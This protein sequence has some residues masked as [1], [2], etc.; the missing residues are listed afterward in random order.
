MFDRYTY[1]AW[2]PPRPP[3]VVAKRL[4]FWALAHACP[5]PDLVL[6]LDAPA[7]VVSARKPEE[8]LEEIAWQRRHFLDLGRRVPRLQ[9]VDATRP[10]AEVKADILER[11]WRAYL[12][13]SRAAG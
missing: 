6:L 11:L 4:Y 10:R 7:E 8:T 12:R 5:A 3:L 13:R 9:V 1:D 2:L